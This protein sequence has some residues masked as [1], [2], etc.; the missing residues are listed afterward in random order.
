MDNPGRAPAHAANG[1]AGARPLS[2][3]TADLIRRGDVAMSAAQEAQHNLRVAL[4]DLYAT[5]VT[6]QDLCR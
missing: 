4:T 2:K 5:R 1:L 3:E 6:S